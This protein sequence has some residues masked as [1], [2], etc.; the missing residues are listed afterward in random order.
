MLA[1]LILDLLRS[2]KLFSTE[3]NNSSECMV[4]LAQTRGEL[5]PR[6]RPA[7]RIQTLT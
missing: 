5:T 2:E 4:E 1:S 3:P 7:E 6:P